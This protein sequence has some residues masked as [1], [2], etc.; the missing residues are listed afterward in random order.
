MPVMKKLCREC[1]SEPEAVYEKLKNLGMDLVTVTDHDSIDSVET[2]RRHADFFL[3]EEVTCTMPS[4]TEAHIAVYD[5]EEHQHIEVQRRR[6]DLPWL[7]AYL[8]EQEILFALNHVFSSLTGRRDKTDFYWF[9]DCFPILE[10][11]NGQLLP[12]HNRMAMELAES[13]KQSVAGGSDA[14]TLFSAG[15]AYTEVRGARTA[16]E[17]LEGLRQGRASVHGRAGSYWKLTRDV[18]WI[19]LQ[20]IREKPITAAL[21]PLALAIPVIT[22]VNYLAEAR[23]A[24]LWARNVMGPSKGRDGVSAP[25][26][27]MDSEEVAV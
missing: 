1:Y 15:S 10:A 2:L 27:P 5:I 25:S 8:E 13:W 7:I 3:S 6:A 21:L 18:L 19:A 23:F 26:V 22:G 16:G 9:E 4:G 14:H 24:R 20:M 11:F 17:F 12:Y